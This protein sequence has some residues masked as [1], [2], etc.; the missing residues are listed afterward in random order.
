MMKFDE[1][2][3]WRH[4]TAARR[5]GPMLPARLTFPFSSPG[6]WPASIES[7]AVELVIEA[8]DA[9]GHLADWLD[10]DWWMDAVERFTHCDTTV[11]ILPTRGALLHP[12][13]L[14]HVQ[15]LRSTVPRWRL[16]GETDRHGI[17]SEEDL[18]ACAAS[19]YHEIRFHERVESASVCSARTSSAPDI[20]ALIGRI[21]RYQSDANL[22]TPVLVRLSSVTNDPAGR[23][24]VRRETPPSLTAANDPRVEHAT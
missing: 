1:Q 17:T 7:E 8:T 4:A 24:E 2:T 18:R 5:R 16:I 12:V 11:R 20:A 3:E 15:M 23:D 13:L 22:T 10:G 6:I 19:G 9:E 21:R 14:H